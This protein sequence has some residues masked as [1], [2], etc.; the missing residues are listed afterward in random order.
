MLDG[1]I[2]FGLTLVGIFVSQYALALFLRLKRVFLPLTKEIRCKITNAEKLEKLDRKQKLD[3]VMSIVIFFLMPF[4]V[5]V[6]GNQWWLLAPYFVGVVIGAVMLR[7]KCNRDENNLYLYFYNY[8]Y[9]V[10]NEL[11]LRD[12][13]VY[14]EYMLY[15]RRSLV[16]QAL[17]AEEKKRQQQLDAKEK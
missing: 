8:R 3:Y 16:L 15:R 17:D 2:A 11:A 13:P 5:L 7:G 1:L 12:D 6:F 10:E 4:L 14:S 9:Y